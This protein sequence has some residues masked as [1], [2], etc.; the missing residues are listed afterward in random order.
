MEVL[1]PGS[2]PGSSLTT[3]PW[4]WEIPILIR[5]PP[6]PKLLT[7]PTM[8]ASTHAACIDH[9]I[10]KIH[11]RQ[12]SS[13]VAPAILLFAGDGRE[14][15]IFYTASLMRGSITDL[16]PASYKEM[17]LPPTA[18]KDVAAPHG[19]GMS[20]NQRL[21]FLPRTSFKAIFKAAFDGLREITSPEIAKNQKGQPLA[22]ICMWE[23]YAEAAPGAVLD[24]QRD[25]CC[26]PQ[27]SCDV[28]GLILDTKQSLDQTKA[29]LLSE[30]VDIWCKNEFQIQ[31][32]PKTSVRAFVA[33]AEL[34]KF[35]HVLSYVDP[36]GKLQL[37]E[38]H[39]Q[40]FL[41]NPTTATHAEDFMCAWQHEVMSPQAPIWVTAP[42]LGSARMPEPIASKPLPASYNSLE[43]LLA[44]TFL[45]ECGSQD[46]AIRLL[47]NKKHEGWAHILKDTTRVEGAKEVSFGR[48][49]RMDKAGLQD[50]SFED[51]TAVPIRLTE[52]TAVVFFKEDPGW[53]KLSSSCLV[54][55]FACSRS[56]CANT[57]Q[58]TVN[59]SSCAS[60]WQ[61][62]VIR[63]SRGPAFTRDPALIQPFTQP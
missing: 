14:K 23:P 47:V 16:D 42:T 13:L 17:Q 18:D 46:A 58:R 1:A 38:A 36:S 49:K 32:H 37:A 9:E 35:E 2:T 41:A 63:P 12:R 51:H 6:S 8:Q 19:E 50:P 56:C 57:C 4:Q 22:A 52:D 43:E 3:S 45:A 55:A 53:A 24:L 11:A 61:H 10:G 54:A 60:P 40:K 29:S 26:K 30:V 20:K 27:E 44:D 62:H 21:A 25:A 34:E 33:N 5:S 59:I 28:R 39:L 48:G 7:E 15:S 31:G